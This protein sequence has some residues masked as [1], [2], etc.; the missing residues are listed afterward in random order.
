MLYHRHANDPLP[1]VA[2]CN[3]HA[4]HE[5]QEQI[6]MLLEGDSSKAVEAA[7]LSVRKPPSKLRAYFGLFILLFANTLNYMDRYTI[8]GILTL[9]R[10]IL[11]CC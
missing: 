10:F 9:V 7:G 2:V 8:A 6:H 1:D 4:T 5:Q 11:L 3:G